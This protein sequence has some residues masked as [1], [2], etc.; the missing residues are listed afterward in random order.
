M[1]WMTCGWHWPKVTA[2]TLINKTMLVRRIKYNHSINH[3]K[4]WLLYSSGHGHHLVRFW[5][6]SVK[7]PSFDKFSSKISDVCFKVKHTIGHISGM[8]GPIDVKQ[9]WGASVGYWVNY[10]TVTFDLTHDLDLWFFKVK[11][12]NSFIWGIVIWL[13]WNKNKAN[14][15]DTGLTV[16]SCSLTTPMTLTL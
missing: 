14:Q 9:K 13:M 7:N 4:T 8:V 16:W 5:R 1:Y 12:Q 15:L 3:Y 11:F 2:V 6:N 10:M